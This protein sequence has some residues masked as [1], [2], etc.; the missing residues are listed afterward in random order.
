MAKLYDVPEARLREVLAAPPELHRDM[1]MMAIQADT[2]AEDIR[3][4]V[5]KSTD[6]GQAAKKTVR[7]KASPHQK[8]ASRVRSLVRLVNRRDFDGDYEQ[9]ATEFS[10]AA[11]SADEL[12]VAADEL[13]QLAHWIR[14]LHRRRG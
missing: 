11:R 13:E 3:Y 14:I 2:T 8:A 12:L 9:I 4:S 10:V 6:S 7:S 5:E 1:L